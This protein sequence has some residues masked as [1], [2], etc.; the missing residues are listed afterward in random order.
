MHASRAFSFVLYVLSFGCGGRSS[1]N[2]TLTKQPVAEA[3][4]AKVNITRNEGE[5]EA[6]F[7]RRYHRAW[8]DQDRRA[9]GIPRKAKPSGPCSVE[10]CDRAAELKGMCGKHYRAEWMKKRGLPF[11]FVEFPGREP[12][13]S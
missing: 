6:D 4:M 5:S 12:R 9:K 1:A 3:A 10:G 2:H 11:E 7:R 8:E 13:T